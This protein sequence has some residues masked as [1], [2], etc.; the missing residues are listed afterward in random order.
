MSNQKVPFD[1]DDIVTQI[2]SVVDKLNDQRGFVMFS[3]SYDHE[4]GILGAMSVWETEDDF[5]ASLGTTL[6]ARSEAL[7]ALGGQALDEPRMYEVVF[8]ELNGGPAPGAMLMLTPGNVEAA[9]FDSAMADFRDRVVP[10]LKQLPGFLGVQQLVDRTTG[11]GMT[12]TVWKD[13]ESL[14][15]A[16]EATEPMRAKSAA[17]GVAFGTSSRREVL[18]ATTR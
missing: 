5:R 4:A 6:A 16:W 8:S 18:F 1:R 3:S 10:R 12:G 13:S 9:N 7:S 11:E 15:K 17:Q 14:E 2:R